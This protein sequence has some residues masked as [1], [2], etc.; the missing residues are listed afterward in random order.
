MDLPAHAI[1]RAVTRHANILKGG[2]VATD[3]ENYESPLMT[4]QELHI[5]AAARERINYTIAKPETSSS[6]RYGDDFSST[7]SDNSTDDG[8][9]SANSTSSCE[10]TASGR[11]IPGTYPETE[12]KDITEAKK[13]KEQEENEQAE[14]KKAEE[15]KDKETQVEELKKKKEDARDKAVDHKAM[16]AQ[17]EANEKE[18][19]KTR[20][21]RMRGRSSRR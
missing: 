20:R 19:K 8:T 3:I 4:F 16:K 11:I 14:K 6:R 18:R 17:D 1:D 15:D 10:K 21:S 5:K 9:P 13:T 12:E 7:S 2:E